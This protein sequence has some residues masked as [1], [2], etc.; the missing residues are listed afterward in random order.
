MLS[1][2]CVYLLKKQFICFFILIY[3]KIIIENG[4]S[5][6]ENKIRE[7]ICKESELN[8]IKNI[9]PL[10]ELSEK[11][12]LKNIKDVLEFLISLGYT[13]QDILKIIN[14]KPSIFS[15][16]TKTLINKINELELLGYTKQEVIKMLKDHPMIFC[17]S[18]DNIKQKIQNMIS[19]GYTE[20]EVI[21]MTP[22]INIKYS[23]ND[24]ENKSILSKRYS[25]SKSIS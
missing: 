3:D 16:S 9:Y 5:M 11:T 21:K 25:L 2:Y 12:L 7:E 4:D 20:K 14:I 17:Y 18:M 10:N 15:Y 23:T 13:K 6:L 24:F 1:L 19:I 8:K 22:F